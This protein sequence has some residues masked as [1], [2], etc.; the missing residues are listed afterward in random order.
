[1]N[2]PYR[3]KD[4]A[5]LKLAPNLNTAGKAFIYP[6]DLLRNKMQNK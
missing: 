4:V 3:P 2:V 1:M 5:P 6:F